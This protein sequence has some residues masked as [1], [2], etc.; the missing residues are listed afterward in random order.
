MPE[1]MSMAE[2][3]AENERLKARLKVLQDAVVEN[4]DGFRVIYV[5]GGEEEAAL[6]GEVES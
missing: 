1:L 3:V 4:G 2:A 5:D 6:Y